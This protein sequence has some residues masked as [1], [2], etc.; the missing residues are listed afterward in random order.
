MLAVSVITPSRSSRT[1]SYRS[2]VIAYPLLGCRV[3]RASFVSLT[4]ASSLFLILSANQK[5]PIP[6]PHGGHVAVIAE[7]A[8]GASIEQ[9]MLPG[10]CMQSN[11]ARAKDA[12]HM[13][14]REQR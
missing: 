12:Q 5:R 11:P 4:V 2:R 7:D 9:E 14:V 6:D 1:A 3:G 10:S 8:Q 13:P